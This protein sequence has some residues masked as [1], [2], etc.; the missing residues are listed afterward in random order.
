ML[1]GQTML[2]AARIWSYAVKLIKVPERVEKPMV[3]ERFF[4]NQETYVG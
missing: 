2:G 3:P 1:V 4:V